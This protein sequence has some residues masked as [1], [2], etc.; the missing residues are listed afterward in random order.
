M[1]EKNT[2]DNEDELPKAFQK[3]KEEEQKKPKKEKGSRMKKSKKS[4]L[5]LFGKIILVLI[6]LLAIIA[7]TIFWFISDKLGKLQQIKIDEKDLGISNAVSANLS[8][9]RNIAIFGVDSRDNNLDKGNRSDCIII[10]SMN[11]SSKE[12][13]LISVYRDTYVQI[14]GHG[15]DK[16]TH[17]YSYGSAPLAI[18]TLN[19]NFD[20]NIEEFVTVNFDSVA[21]AVD[22]LGGVTINVE[23]QEELKYLNSY[24]DETARVTGK[25]NEKVTTIGKQT[26]N[27]V[28][29]VAY[30]RIRYTAGGDYK[31]TER[32]RTVIEAMVS[33]LK[34]K[35][36]TEINSFIDFILPKVYTNI[37]AGDIFSLLPS[38]A[39]VSIK[40][41]IGWP[42][43]T[44][45][46][47]LDRWYGVPVTLKSNV[48]ELHQEAFGETNYIPSETVQTISDKI[49]QKTGYSQ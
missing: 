14:E 20:L 39:S 38:V 11:N 6:I 1:A 34:T 30:S 32:M 44:K 22:K 48:S 41:S 28:Q 35:N 3:D 16:I 24:I 23:T 29:A 27:G 47:T 45:G 19:T 25:S 26:L 10:A 36:I 9:Y 17:A 13:K 2:Y 8:G 12:V 7:G 18:K 15:L 49:V 4:G 33:K 42:Y 46:I 40:D 31:R 37:T 43:E 21:E 5:K